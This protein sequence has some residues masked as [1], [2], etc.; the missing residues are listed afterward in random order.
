MPIIKLELDR[1]TPRVE[2]ALWALFLEDESQ[3]GPNR[4]VASRWRARELFQQ[5]AACRKSS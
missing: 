5:T 1:L 2:V 3:P 4:G